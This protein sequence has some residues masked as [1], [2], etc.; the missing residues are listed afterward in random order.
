MRDSF[1][2]LTVASVFCAGISLLAQAGIQS[3]GQQPDGPARV[4]PSDMVISG[5]LK[6]SSSDVGKGTTM[7]TLEGRPA[8][9]DANAPGVQALPEVATAPRVAPITP[10]NRTYALSSVAT[11]RL[12]E[13][14]GQRVQ[15]TGRL[16]PPTAELGTTG[17]TGTTGAQAQGEITGGHQTFEVSGVKML[18]MT[19]K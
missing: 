5:C 10:A 1:A 17:T 9:P 8:T 6:S 14:V 2:G 15:L 11:V 7:Y 13:H 18:S 16:Q 19:C 4:Q 3:T 12:A